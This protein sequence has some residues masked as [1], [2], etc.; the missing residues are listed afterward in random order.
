MSY[1]ARG[2]GE[3][4][5]HYIHRIIFFFI[6]K[7]ILFFSTTDIR[8]LLFVEKLYI[9]KTDTVKSVT[10]GLVD[11]VF[12]NGLGD[13]VSIPSRVIPKMP[14][15]FITEDYKVRIKDKVEHSK[16]RSSTFPNTWVL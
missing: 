16:E 10:F 15:C 7:K 13:C 9:F 12:A 5:D 4:L 14:P 6:K 1:S 8:V 11:K 2:G 3:G